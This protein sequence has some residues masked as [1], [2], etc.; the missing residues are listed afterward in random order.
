MKIGFD[1][2]PSYLR[3]Q[4]AQALRSG[5]L[6]PPYSEFA[7]KAAMSSV[8]DSGKVTQLL[9]GLDNTGVGPEGIAFG[10]QCFDEGASIN[11]L[12]ELAWTGPKVPGLHARATRKVYEEL[13]QTAT[14]SLWIST[15]A[16]FDGPKAFELL[17]SRM[18]QVANLQVNL[19]LNIQRKWGDTTSSNVLISRFAKQFWEKDWPGSRQPRVFFDKRSLGN[20]ALKGV[21]HAKAVVRDEQECFI[22]S[23]NLTEAAFDKNIEAGVVLRNPSIAKSLI[24]YFQRLIEEEW[25]V[26]LHSISGEGS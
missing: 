11:P 15:Y 24:R 16:F 1:F 4:L 8:E 7:I 18:D 25:L 12:P 21:L 22:T 20:E 13:F 3:K 19:I 10:L 14:E 6:R 17:A 23:A 2:L 9:S 5:S 26:P